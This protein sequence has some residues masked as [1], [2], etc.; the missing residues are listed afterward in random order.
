[1]SP[2]WHLKF[3]DKFETLMMSSDVTHG[4]WKKVAGFVT[5]GH[6][7]VSDD[8]A[9]KVTSTTKT[10]MA[11]DHLVAQHNINFNS[12]RTMAS[13]EYNLMGPSEGASELE[14]DL[15]R[16]TDGEEMSFL[17]MDFGTTLDDDT[18]ISSRQGDAPTLRRSDRQRIPSWKVRENADRGDVALPAAYEVLTC[19]IFRNRHCR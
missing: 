10:T 17:P 1:V 7:Q 14:L 9:H 12:N 11:A 6:T 18:V 13:K 15:G 2:Q 19:D 8:V 16:G 3:D 5:M 4:Y